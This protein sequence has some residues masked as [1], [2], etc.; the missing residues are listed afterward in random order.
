MRQRTGKPGIRAVPTSGVP[1][2]HAD[3]ANPVSAHPTLDRFLDADCVTNA[4]VPGQES[5]SNQPLWQLHV[6]AE[7]YNPAVRAV[8][9]AILG[10][11]N[12]LHNK[13]PEMLKGDPIEVLS[14]FSNDFVHKTS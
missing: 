14:D 1:G 11:P 5:S 7:H 3:V 13:F 6:L 2:R 8:A 9:T 10:N 4:T 12:A